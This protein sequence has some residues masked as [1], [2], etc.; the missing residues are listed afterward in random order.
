MLGCVQLG[1]T[2]VVAPTIRLHIVQQL[3]GMRKYYLDLSIWPLLKIK[4]FE[5]YEYNE[6]VEYVLS[7]Y[8]LL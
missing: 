3:T 1:C 8:L 7:K 6:G 2:S 4:K 5:L